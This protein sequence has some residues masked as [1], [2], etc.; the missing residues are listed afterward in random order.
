MRVGIPEFSDKKQLFSYLKSNQKD[1]IAK[2]KAMP[3]KSEVV[4]EL[5]YGCVG[6]TANDKKLVGKSVTKMVG[7]DSNLKEGELKVDAL[8]NMA[9]WCDSYDD[10][11]IP[12]CFNKTISSV[13]ASNK[14]LVYHLKNHDH[15]TDA[16]VGGEVMMSTRDIDLSVFNIKT[17]L[18]T[19]EGLIGSS[20]VRRKYCPKTYDLY[21]DDEIKQHSIGLQYVKIYLCINSEDEEY[22]EELADYKKYYKY[23]INKDKV[24]A[25]GYFW[26]VVE[27]KLLEY[28]AVLWGASELTTVQETSKN[29]EPS[30][31]LDTQKSDPEAVGEKDTS[32]SKFYNRLN[33]N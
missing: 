13:G 4:S 14:Q 29:I 11:L 9:G 28:S 18:K 27:I 23:V 16:I 2:K 21:L 3:I 33:L 22:K 19:S 30:E 24:D 8:A 25:Q 6:L 1:I 20:I 15:T 10:V 5:A 26:A 7:E 12:K 31:D 32:L 17:D